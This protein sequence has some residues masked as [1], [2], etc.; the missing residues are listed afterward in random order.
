MVGSY[1]HFVF[2]AELLWLLLSAADS[3]HL[4]EVGCCSWKEDYGV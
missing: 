2:G 1:V 4:D 3:D